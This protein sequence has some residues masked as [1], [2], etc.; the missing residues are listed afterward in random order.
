MGMGMGEDMIVPSSLAVGH[1]RNPSMG[2][3]MR[4][5]LRDVAC[6]KVLYTA[7]NVRRHSDTV[8]VFYR[9]NWLELSQFFRER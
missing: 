2:L 6:K 9:T 5:D 8:L 1:G 3:Y 7:E 4:C